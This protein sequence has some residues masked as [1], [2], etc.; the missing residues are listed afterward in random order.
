MGAGSK[1]QDGGEPGHDVPEL[2]RAVRGGQEA[3]GES[4]HVG[5][6]GQYHAVQDTPLLQELQNV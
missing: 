6:K 4:E 3:A 2:H 5:D 1:A